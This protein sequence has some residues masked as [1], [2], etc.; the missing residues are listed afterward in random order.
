M[1]SSRKSEDDVAAAPPVVRKLAEVFTPTRPRPGRKWLTGRRLELDRVVDALLEERAH[2]VLYSERGRGKTSLSNSVVEVLRS[3]NVAVARYTCSSGSSFEDIISSLLRDLP[4]SLLSSPASDQVG[5]GCEAALPDGKL[6]PSDVAALP[7]RLTCQTLVCLVD[8]FDRVSDA[9]VRKLVADTIKQISDRGARLL[10]ML[11][12]AS[13]SLDQLLGEHLS[14]RRNLV[15]VS[16]PLL[17][18][19]EIEQLIVSGATEAGLDFPP[20]LVDALTGLSRGMPYIAQL[21]GLRVA[22]AAAARG[23]REAVASDLRQAAERLVNEAEPRVVSL[24]AALTQ[25]G[26]D[27]EMTRSLH[28]ISVAEQDTFGCIYATRAGNHVDL[29]GKQVEFGCWQRVVKAGVLQP[30]DL[31]PMARIAISDR[32]F[33]TYVLLRSVLGA[34]VSSAEGSFEFPQSSAAAKVATVLTY[35]EED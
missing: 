2:V 27:T 20:S 16:L 29:G 14:I 35:S 24:Y 11:I 9:T 17:S 8:E 25:H 10:F 5:R 21:L 23:A 6:R 22:Q 7:P 3:R 15:A 26:A 19:I 34:D 13:D 18:T 32:D 1:S 33:L 28:S 4:A 12:G 31:T 30:L